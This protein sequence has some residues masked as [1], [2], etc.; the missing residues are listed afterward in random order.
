MVLL[1]IIGGTALLYLAAL[2]LVYRQQARIA[3]WSANQSEGNFQQLFEEVPLACQ[4]TGPDGVIRRVNQKLCD[5]RGLPSS[6]ILGKHYADF[7]AEKDRDGIRE[8][9]HR[10]LT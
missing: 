9:T 8:E 1:Y 2:A 4:E 3:K 7:A 10:K 5:L 6:D